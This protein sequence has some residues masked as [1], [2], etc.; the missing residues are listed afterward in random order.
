MSASGL[1][2]DAL[3]QLRG[4]SFEVVALNNALVAAV[5]KHLVP[6]FA[7]QM[8]YEPWWWPKSPGRFV[9]DW[10]LKDSQVSEYAS[11]SKGA[12]KMTNRSCR[13]EGFVGSVAATKGAAWLLSIRPSAGTFARSVGPLYGAMLN[14][15]NGYDGSMV[16]E[17]HVTDLV[18]FRGPTKA[19]SWTVGVTDRMLRACTECLYDEYLATCPQIILVVDWAAAALRDRGSPLCKESVLRTTWRSDPRTA[20]LDTFLSMIENTG[21]PVPFW[22][23][24]NQFNFACA[25]SSEL[26]DYRRGRAR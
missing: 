22:G 11:L 1:P 4:V 23:Q 19:T 5:Q 7:L 18:K 8:E 14:Y 20:H 9:A 24:G 21:R 3:E 2:G 12:A 16:P 13:Y 26:R 17:L 6:Q 25:L 15:A 10:G